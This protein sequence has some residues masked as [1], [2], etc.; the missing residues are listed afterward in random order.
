M[1]LLWWCSEKKNSDKKEQLH[2]KEFRCGTSK[3]NFHVQCGH[4]CGFFLS[5]FSHKI[6]FWKIQNL[7]AQKTWSIS[8]DKQASRQAIALFYLI[9]FNAFFSR[10]IKHAFRTAKPKNN[11]LIL[12]FDIF[13]LFPFISMRLISSRNERFSAHRKLLLIP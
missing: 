12:F 9:M 13:S 7:I 1:L 11:L 10:K 2:F 3:A 5:Q 8:T 4:F 6:H